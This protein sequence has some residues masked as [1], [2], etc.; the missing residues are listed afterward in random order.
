MA[1]EN[2]EKGM[3]GHL[4]A[5]WNLLGFPVTSDNTTPNNLFGGLTRTI[6]YWNS[7]QKKFIPI[8]YSDEAFEIGLG[9][10]LKL[11]EDVTITVPY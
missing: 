11:E 5:G 8:S 3:A 6:Y 7:S 4:V 9:Y 1:I 10:W 2:D